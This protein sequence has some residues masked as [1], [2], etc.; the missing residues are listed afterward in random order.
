MSIIDALFPGGI[1]ADVDDLAIVMPAE[2]AVMIDAAQAGMVNHRVPIFSM[3]DGRRFIAARVA[4][5]A[6]SDGLFP[7]VAL[8]PATVPPGVSVIPMADAKALMVGNAEV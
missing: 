4:R 1:P 3:T 2:V 5:E 8:L 6:R 7:R